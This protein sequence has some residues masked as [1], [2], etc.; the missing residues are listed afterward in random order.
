MPPHADLDPVPHSALPTF[1]P[2]SSP[3]PVMPAAW[4]ATALLHP[5]SPPPSDHPKINQ[6]FYQL[7]IAQL[8][9]LAG[10]YF[11]A[12]VV[13]TEY[14]Q[15]WFIITPSGTKLSTDG[16][17]FWSPVNMGWSLPTNW[18][19][20]QASTAR[21]PGA[22]PLNWMSDRLAEWWTIQ[23]PIPT[24]ATSP[25]QGTAPVAATWM[26]FDAQTK[27]PLRMMFGN[28]PPLP[29]F[30]DS[31]QLAFLQMFSF[32][33]FASYMELAAADAPAEPLDW[34]KP[35]IAGFTAGNPQGFKP[36]IWNGNSGIT[37]FMTP[38]NGYYN[39]LPTR[40]LYRWA[41]DA[42]YESYT[43]RV[44]STLMH[45]NYNP[46]QP[47]GQKPSANQTA[48]LTG[49][50][51]KSISNPPALAGKGFLYIQYD[52]GTQD[53]IKGGDFRY[54][55]EPPDWVSI[56]AAHG[57]I[58]GT[59]VDNPDFCPGQTITLYSV[60]FPPAAPNYPEATY[61]WTWYAPDKGGDGTSSRPVTFMQ[62]QSKLSQGT[63]LALAD[64]YFYQTFADPID[65]ENL[66]IPPYCLSDNCKVQD[67]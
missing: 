44:Q 8:D 37:A 64:Y 48:L 55:Q 50:A 66:T 46:S 65:P 52:D 39:P 42:D 53:C 33:Y 59:I 60:L 10:T 25:A 62:S 4:S 6:P 28:G 56:P 11:S 51:P 35:T 9:Y 23:V 45:Y 40:V 12:K 22:A 61:L 5:F 29:N 13:G 49:A 3:A 16:G 31:T 63:S 24:G 38:V 57:T 20:A 1:A 36:F 41:A 54:G 21:S 17:I 27:A 43:D 67:K 7:C 34:S 15:W 18:Y 14:G 58:R 30:G 26:W 19:G 2:V 32:S 47:A